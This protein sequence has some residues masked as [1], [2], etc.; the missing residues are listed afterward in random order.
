RA[1]RADPGRALQQHHD[2][3]ALPLSAHRELRSRHGRGELLP[4]R[5]PRLPALADRRAGAAFE[6]GPVDIATAPVIRVRRAVGYL[7]ML[8]AAIAFLYPIYWMVT[9]SLKPGVSILDDPLGFDPAQA[10]LRNWTGMFVNVP[11]VH[12][13]MNT[14]IVVVVKGGVLMVF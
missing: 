12:A 5:H 9:S 4:A 7:A 3:R 13:L 8:L 14:L 1:L 2:I 11:I 6:R 10:T